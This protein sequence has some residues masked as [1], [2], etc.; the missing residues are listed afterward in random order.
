MTRVTK[1]SRVGFAVIKV[2]S[3]NTA[4]FLM[5]LNPR[6]KDINFIGGHQEERDRGNLQKTT[7]R[8]LW[9]EVP[10]I[11]NYGKLELEALTPETR[12]GPILSRS[13]GGEVV[14][15]LQFFLLKLSK[16]PVRLVE[17]LGSRTRNIW[18]KQE[19]LID[20]RRFRISGLVKLLNNIF[21]GGLAAIPY[22]S[23][24]DLNDIRGRFERD[25]QRQLELALK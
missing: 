7:R 5:R 17:A 10:S 11:R 24:A 14:Y 15:Q 1:H 12:Y 13:R 4:Y 21:P 6:W 2:R 9:E 23:T 16:D 8:E 19:D 18:V 20:Q 25:D 3:G 22:T